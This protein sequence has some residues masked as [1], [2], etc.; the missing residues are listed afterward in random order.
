MYS[1]V[2]YIVAMDK[3]MIGGLYYYS[4][5]YMLGDLI[6]RFFYR[7]PTTLNTNGADTEG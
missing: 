2:A 1:D 5:A 6:T 7:N 4:M 3:T